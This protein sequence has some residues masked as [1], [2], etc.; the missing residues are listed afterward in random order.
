LSNTHRY[1]VGIDLMTHGKCPSKW[2][3]LLLLFF[4]SP[5]DDHRRFVAMI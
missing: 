2:T 3:A 5:S 4:I 1:D